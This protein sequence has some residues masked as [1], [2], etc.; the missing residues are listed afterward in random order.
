[1]TATPQIA[2][3]RAVNVGGRGTI[4]M[5]ALRRIFEAAGCTEVRTWIQSG[6]VIY[7]APGSAGAALRGRIGRGLAKHLGQDVGVA[8]RSVRELQ[9]SVDAS[10]FGS[11]EEGPDVGFYVGFL[12][13]TPRRRSRLPLSSAKDGLEVVGMTKHEVFVV[14]R[15][16]KG[17]H[18]FPNNLIEKDLGV[19]AT[20]RNW[21]TVRKVLAL[22]T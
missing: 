2:F 15:R 18:G 5:N 12:I 9:Q 13:A 19:P 20:T 1:M 7:R 10:P 8:Y 4:Q 17:R 16:V 14:S 21:N 22:A 3:L 6:N 11:L